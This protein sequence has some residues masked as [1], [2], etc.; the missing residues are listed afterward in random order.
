M[1]DIG[2]L[3]GFAAASVALAVAP[4]PDNLFVL[5]RSAIQGPKAGIFVTLGLC[6]GLLFHTLAVGLGVAVIFKTSSFAFSVLK[7]GGAGYMLFLAWQAFNAPTTE[8]EHDSGVDSD[9]GKLYRQGVILNVTNPK[10]SIFFLAFLPQ[11]VA[12][13]SGLVFL[14]TLVLGGVFVVSTIFVFGL[15]AIVS[16]SLR[17]YYLQSVRIQNVLNWIAGMV[18]LG[19][20]VKLLLATQS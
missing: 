3:F 8:C 1:P 16:G 18:F 17:R 7:F 9:L 12:E 13:E 15:I 4:G 2:N 11:F 20:A 19:I 14:Q 5:T 6:T 10:V